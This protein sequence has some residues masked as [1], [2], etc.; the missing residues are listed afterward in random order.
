MNAMSPRDQ[1]CADPFFNPRDFSS[2]F[3]VQVSAKKSSIGGFWHFLDSEFHRVGTVGMRE[4]SD[5]L[6]VF[7]LNT[8]TRFEV[9]MGNEFAKSDFIPI[10]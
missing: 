1:N 6:K 7:P 4:K 9:D 10:T 8:N 2:R 3:L 5:H